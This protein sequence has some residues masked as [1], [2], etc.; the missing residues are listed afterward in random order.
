MSCEIAQYMVHACMLMKKEAVKTDSQE[1]VKET[2]F[3]AD[4]NI[5]LV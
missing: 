4:Q 5:T 1:L 3:E 2:I